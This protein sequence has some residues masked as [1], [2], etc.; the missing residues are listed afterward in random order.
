MFG[1]LWHISF[2][3]TS[4][5]MRRLLLLLLFFIIHA[6][7]SSTSVFRNTLS[8]ILS[9]RISENVDKG[10]NTTDRKKNANAN[11]QRALEFFVDVVVVFMH[12]HFRNEWCSFYA[13]RKNVMNVCSLYAWKCAWNSSHRFHGNF[14]HNLVQ[15]ASTPCC[16]YVLN[17]FY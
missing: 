3:S 10:K 2:A 1:W 5:R 9:F 15:I 13:R 12:F 6:V 14:L 17:G 8:F 16:W 4:L 11:Q 7:S